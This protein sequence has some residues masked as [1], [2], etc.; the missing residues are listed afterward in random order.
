M[1]DDGLAEF[2]PLRLVS[3]ER[4]RQIA[5]IC[6]MIRNA[7]YWVTN[8]QPPAPKAPPKKGED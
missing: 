3:P 4:D 6:Q 5:N 2:K 8:T 1:R 7:V